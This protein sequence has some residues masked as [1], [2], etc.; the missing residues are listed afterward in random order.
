MSTRPG[1][2]S[3]S[4][5]TAGQ[6]T[7]RTARPLHGFQRDLV[8]C[9][10]HHHDVAGD[11]RQRQAAGRA[12]LELARDPLGLFVAAPLLRKRRQRNEQRNR[13]DDHFLHT[14]DHDPDAIRAAAVSLPVRSSLMSATVS[15][16]SASFVL[17]FSIR[18]CCA[19]WLAGSE[20]TAA[21][22]S[23]IA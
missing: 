1:R 6:L 15:C 9:S 16:S 11:I 14:H 8:A 21:R 23:S 12:D 7:S 20:R 18:L 13:H 4:I 5:T 19:C 10:G 22:L 2:S 3:M 17:K